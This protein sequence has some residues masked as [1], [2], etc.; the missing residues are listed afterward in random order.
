MSLLDYLLSGKK[1]KKAK[2]LTFDARQQEGEKADL[3]FKQAYDSFS[4]VS[5][6]YSKYADALYYWGFALLHQA[7]TKPSD[8]AIKIFE[9]AIN[10][11]SFCK[12]IAPKHL[13]AMVDG[14]VALLGQAKSKKVNLDD[15]LYIKAKE[16]FESAENIQ[17]GSASYNLACMY[18]LQ[19]EGDACLK[20]L[21]NARDHGLVPDEQDIIN[22]DDLQNIKKLSWFAEYIN[23]LEAKEED[24]D[25]QKIVEIYESD[26]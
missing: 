14:G 2:K 24:E 5:E 25:E 11:F 23:S 21:E 9:E 1:L 7:Q 18:A 12:T 20:A 26:D 16:S 17:N 10:K 3:L 13:G 22:D 4:D 19:N 6:S 15:D 8:E